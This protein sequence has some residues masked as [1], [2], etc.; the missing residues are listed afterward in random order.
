MNWV[1]IRDQKADHFINREQ[2][3]GRLYN[4]KSN[5]Q[6][7]VIGLFTS[8][9]DSGLTFEQLQIVNKMFMVNKYK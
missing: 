6:S 8:D 9:S 2:L 7:L 3:C 1:I 4:K 5:L